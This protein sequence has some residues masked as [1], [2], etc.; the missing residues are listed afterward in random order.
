MRDV[1]QRRAAA[2]AWVA[3]STARS[4]LW[5]PSAVAGCPAPE[6]SHQGK[7]FPSLPGSAPGSHRTKTVWLVA[8]IAC[9]PAPPRPRGPSR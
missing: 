9:S 4:L 6:W 1:W 8:C 7:T 5:S 3:A 2:A